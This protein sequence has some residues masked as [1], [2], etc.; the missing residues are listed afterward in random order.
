MFYGS[1]GKAEALKELWLERERERERALAKE[2]NTRTYNTLV[3]NF[4]VQRIEM[5]E[6]SE[7]DCSAS[8]VKGIQMHRDNNYCCTAMYEV[9]I[10]KRCRK[11]GD[12]SSSRATAGKCRAI[13]MLH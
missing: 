12:D 5:L 13:T 6:M 7:R 10:L 2:K 1:T 9:C 8:N 3:K 11:E 4:S